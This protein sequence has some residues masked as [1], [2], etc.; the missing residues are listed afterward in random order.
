MSYTPDS[1]ADH[2]NC[3]GTD[4][5]TSTVTG[6]S[7]DDQAGTSIVLNADT[8]HVDLTMPGLY[9][10]QVFVPQDS[11]AVP[12]FSGDTDTSDGGGAGG[13]R[14][15]KVNT[16]AQ[17]RISLSSDGITNGAPGAGAGI[18]VFKVS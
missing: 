15:V 18:T 16:T 9:Y 17:V 13:S 6:L 8:T 4:L 1:S 5:D 11:K 10:V 2:I 12:G 7:V 14:M 3:Y